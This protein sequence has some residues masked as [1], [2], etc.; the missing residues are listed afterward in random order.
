MAPQPAATPAPAT[1]NA[2]R[3]VEGKKVRIVVSGDYMPMTWGQWEAA[4][5]G[6]EKGQDLQLPKARA[7]AR[8][9]YQVAA[10]PARDA[11]PLETDS[12]ET[13]GSS[14][15]F[16]SAR[17]NPSTEFESAEEQTIAE[18]LREPYR[19]MTAEELQAIRNRNPE[20]FNRVILSGDFNCR[21]TDPVVVAR[22]AQEEAEA[23]RARILLAAAERK[24]QRE[25]CGVLRCPHRE[26]GGCA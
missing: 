4:G 10:R 7:R 11:T 19:H 14:S 22:R 13:R 24:R 12:P 17:S 26:S 21:D 3:A 15:I 1:E 5:V 23:K 8:P 2:G 18:V 16:D 20:L 6:K 9:R 25:R